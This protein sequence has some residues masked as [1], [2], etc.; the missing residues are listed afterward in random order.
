MAKKRTKIHE[1][2]T[3]KMKPSL[4]MFLRFQRICYNRF[5]EEDH[6]SFNLHLYHYQLPFNF[7]LSYF[8]QLFSLSLSLSLS[9]SWLIDFIIFTL[10]VSSSANKNLSENVSVKF[11]W[12]HHH[13]RWYLGVF[14]SV[15]LV[16]MV[17]NCDEI[18]KFFFSSSYFSFQDLYTIIFI[19]VIYWSLRP[20]FFI[21]SNTR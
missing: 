6:G 5:H 8:Y 16:E 21:M 4:K 9:L 11:I 1:D 13:E 3:I 14:D 18:K 19:I 2:E 15:I 17:G 20:F 12:I 10:L 7:F